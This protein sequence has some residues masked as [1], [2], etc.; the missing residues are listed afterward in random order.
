M[1]KLFDT[2]V[3]KFNE[4]KIIKKQLENAHRLIEL[5]QKEKVQAKH[6][7]KYTSVCL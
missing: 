2:S 4:M 5:K 7:K 3:S 6:N 1:A